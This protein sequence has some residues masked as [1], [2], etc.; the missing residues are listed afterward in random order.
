MR[1]ALPKGRL[2]EETAVL[3]MEAGWGLSDYSEGARL[4]NLTSTNFPDLKAKIFHEKDIPIQ[5]AMGNYD[6][7]ICGL[8]WIQELTVK[9]PASGLVRVTDLHYGRLSLYLAASRRSHLKTLR[10]LQQ[11]EKTVSIASEYPNLAE[12]LALNCR[13]KHFNIFPVWGAAEIFPPEN[14]DLVLIA[15]RTGQEIATGNLREM[16][17]ILRSSAYLIANR[18]AW[19]SRDLSQILNT[20]KTIAG[21]QDKTAGQVT[22]LIIPPGQE[23]D[24]LI[25]SREENI[26]P[27]LRNNIVPSGA[28][29]PESRTAGTGQISLALPD[30]HAQKHVVNILN[31]AGILIQDYPANNGNRRPEIGIPGY[32]VKVIRPQDMPLQVANGNFDIAITGK[33][34]VLEHLY[35]FP[36]SPVVE[37]LDLK[38]SRVKI[39]AAV[40]NDLPVNDIGEL[41]QFVAAR[42]L[43]LRVASE[44]VSIADK[45]ARDHHL[46]TYRVIPTWGAT[47]AFV[48]DD[49]DMLIENTETGNTLKRHNLKI[50]EILFESTACLIA[51]KV[52]LDSKKAEKIYG[53]ADILRRAIEGPPL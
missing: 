50:I 40:H 9:Y 36:S 18:A 12:S 1:I 44:Y 30:G 26:N 24:A 17:M 8:D 3:A 21:K 31:K 15:A 34:W 51:N 43:R 42:G 7:G 32:T 46:G 25:A 45:Y 39:V 27:G 52:S 41:R 23:N 28:V 16:N 5:V 38:Y 11:S 13:C 48:P 10:D 53:F 14:A 19:E 22:G 2:L 49:A 4:Y 20:L 29:V 33:D 6:L 37:L 47:E 35:K